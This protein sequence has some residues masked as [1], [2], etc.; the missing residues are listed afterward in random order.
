M[1][2][3]THQDYAKTVARLVLTSELAPDVRPYLV[4]HRDQFVDAASMPDRVAE[5]ACS[6]KTVL[7]DHNLSSF[8]HFQP[9][10]RW[11]RDP[12][13]SVAGLLTGAVA[14]V[15][16]MRITANPDGERPPLTG[17]LELTPM[18]RAALGQPGV[19][20]GAFHFP[21]ASEGADHFASGARH[22]RGERNFAGW[23]RCAGYALHFVQDACVPHHVWGALLLGHAQWEVQLEASWRETMRET[24]QDSGIFQA[25]V[26]RAVRAALVE[27]DECRTVGELC[28]ANAAATVARFG[29][30]HDLVECPGNDA[31]AVSIRAIASSLRACQLMTGG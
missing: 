12:S 18:Q 25:T 11:D 10:Y 2:G 31:L 21:S 27:L 26:A 13:L 5:V 15:A 20:L 28:E 6:G 17:L 16:G 7:L 29:E 4:D 19:T 23:R 3:N 14:A 1:N 30:P 22:W 9:G 24:I 8:E